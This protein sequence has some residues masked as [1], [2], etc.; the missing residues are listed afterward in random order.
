[1]QM[2]LNFSEEK[3]PGYVVLMAEKTCS[4]LISDVY[5]TENY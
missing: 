1:M 5:V 2:L 3:S 4:A